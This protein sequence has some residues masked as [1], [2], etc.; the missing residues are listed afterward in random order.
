MGVG[1]GARREPG[2]PLGRVPQPAAV[3]KPGQRPARVRGVGAVPLPCQ[4]REALARV[5]L[6]PLVELQSG[7]EIG[8]FFCLAGAPVLPG[9]L[10]EEP[11]RFG[12][13]PA[14]RPVAREE[15]PRRSGHAW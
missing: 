5:R 9:Q 4:A 11:H 13:V 3:R 15:E 8:A 6:V 1:I 12:I 7:S 14:A 10:V 2:E